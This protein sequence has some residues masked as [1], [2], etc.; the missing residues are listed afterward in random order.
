MF[1][2]IGRSVSHTVEAFCKASFS[3]E[4]VT[5]ART[6]V[7]EVLVTYLAVFSTWHV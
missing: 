6:Q 1:S 4:K 2:I 3:A 5:E 7:Y